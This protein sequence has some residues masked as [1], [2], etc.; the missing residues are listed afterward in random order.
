M[1]QRLSIE[2]FHRVTAWIICALVLC[3]VP[4]RAQDLPNLGLVRAEGGGY[5]PDSLLVKFKPSANAS[6]KAQAR[7]LVNAASGK[8]F[9][10]VK[11][12]EALRLNPGQRLVDAVDKLAR[13]PF[14]EYAEPDY[15]VQLTTTNDE[16]YSLIYAIENTGQ[17]IYG[18]TGTVDA[19]MDVVEAWNT[20]TGNP[21]L[22][23]AVI[24][25][26][27]DYNHPDL[28]ANMWTNTAEIPGNGIDD[29]NNGF[30][31]DVHGYD[32]YSSDGEPMD[33]DGHGTHV[34][35][36][37]CA[38][39]NNGIGIV[40][41][42]QQCQIMALRFLGPQ[43]G[44]VSDAISSLDYAVQMGATISNNSWGGG[45]FSSAL[46]DAIGAAGDADHV[47]LAAAGNGGADQVGDNNDLLPHYPSDYTLTNI[48][49]VAA[50]DNRDALADFSNFGA[51]SVD[52]GAPG[53]DIASTYIN[54]GYVWMSGTSM[55]TP[56]VTGVVA[57]IRSQNPGWGYQQ[58]IDH[59]YATGRQAA[60][61]VGVTSQGVI[62][63]A[64][65]AVAP[66]EPTSPPAAPT[67]LSADSAAVTENS[68]TL[69]W[70]DNADN[71][72]AFDIERD[73][74]V[75]TDTLGANV[76]SFTDTGLASA[77]LYSYRVRARNVAG[78]S[79]WSNQTD[80]TTATPPPF[81][82]VQVS[83]ETTPAGTIVSGNYTWTY[84]N[85][86]QA[87]VI[88]ER[89]SGGRKPSRYSYVDHR[90]SLNAPAGSAILTVVGH[91][92][93][94][95]DGDDFIMAYST[96]GAF[97]P[98]CTLSVV[99]PGACTTSFDLQSGGTVTVRVTDT[100]QSAGNRSLD[101]VHI[102]QIVMTVESTG[103]PVTEPPF[104]P[105]N[106]T[107]NAG[108]PGE[109][110]LSWQDLADNETSYRVDR[111]EDGG[112]TWME[113]AVLPANTADHLDDS[114]ASDTPY[115]YQVRAVNSAG[116][117]V[118]DKIDVTS[119]VVETPSIS[120]TANGYKR[121]GWQNVDANWSAGGTV[122]TLYRNSTPVYS[123]SNSNHTDANI[124]KGGAVYD[125]QVCPASDAP[126]SNSCS[127]VVRIVF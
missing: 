23:I 112:N 92:D 126:G 86:D 11:N 117:G 91:A 127:N 40:G 32:F 83:G 63:N 76:T 5:A 89:E 79:T 85:D 125:Y 17:S 72:T 107:G 108:T 10:L 121:K 55:A 45:G 53:V 81:Q 18:Q 61:L 28:A 22:V 26:G 51:T 115:S 77:T 123:G 93:I 119:A 82:V 44:S 62:A 58:A 73:G 50:T 19:D 13:L 42:V 31:D 8:A 54:N 64:A 96:G 99:A 34:A 20:Q 66:V 103:G 71:E 30:T 2:V 111:S 88:S 25:T 4:A 33:E 16:F 120:L 41:V 106:L 6:Q 57:L 80:V 105:T 124:S 102:D 27:V 100:N 29:D 47:F 52:I 101:R 74:T 59:L 37:I 1:N 39:A 75:L 36:T 9:G 87:E 113:L 68:V 7:G 38:I 43:G 60:S 35:G 114:V 118:S 65:N 48:V 104:A 84:T 46:R 90:W 97:N 69:S 98:I 95:S 24:D 21:G 67:D 122:V 3:S 70:T 15:L 78:N 110:A 109:I 49:S 12:L 94:S 56:N 14:V 116:E